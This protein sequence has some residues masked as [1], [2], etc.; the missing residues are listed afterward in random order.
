VRAVQTGVS[1]A[2][3][4]FFS[5]PE[6]V[7]PRRHRDYN[8]WH[9]LDHLPENRA[10][11]GVIHGVRWV[12]TPA[13]RAA[14]AALGASDPTLDAAQYVAMYWFAEAADGRVEQSVD[15]WRELG[16]TTRQQGRRPE[17]DWTVRR[18]TGTFRPEAGTVAPRALVSVG[19]LPF[20]PHRGVVLDVLRVHNPVDLD[21]APLAPGVA[22]AW[23]FTSS[24]VQVQPVG[25]GL[26]A[27]PGPGGLRVT[28]HY[29]DEDPVE[30]VAG[31]GATDV[32]G[33]QP[34]L[35]TPLLPVVPWEWDWFD[36]TS[37]EGTRGPA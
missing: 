35:R 32:P 33:A 34:L 31:M 9:Q 24:R 16:E 4:A 6:V 3:L 2:P 22:G 10:L 19:A 8:A 23:T 36:E 17:L 27:D 28:L 18:M 21:P 1:A 12:R 11:R 15:E 25:A 14:S 29:C 37:E 20:H 5:F 7:D 30:V 13:C 26:A